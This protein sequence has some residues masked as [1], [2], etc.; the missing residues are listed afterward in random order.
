MDINLDEQKPAI[1]VL[2]I[3]KDHEPA[4]DEKGNLVL[5]NW[6]EVEWV[7]WAKKGTNGAETVD[8]ISRVRNANQVV[9]SV[10]EPVYERWKQGQ[11]DPVEGTPLD[12]WPAMTKGMIDALRMINIRSIED[13]A[14]TNDAGLENIGMGARVL[15]DKARHYLKAREGEGALAEA[16]SQRDNTIEDLRRRLDELEAANA[17]LTA[18]RKPGRPPKDVAQGIADDAA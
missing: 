14:E 3:W 4:K 5:D 1:I 8:K 2:E 16:L 10:V 11:E 17:S 9:W 7:R 18:K 13:L 15:R 6:A 12:V